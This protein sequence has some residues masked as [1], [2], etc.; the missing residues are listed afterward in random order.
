MAF[1]GELQSQFSAAQVSG[2]LGS[3]NATV[4]AAGTTQATG[5]AIAAANN[6]ITTATLNQGV[7]LPAGRAVFDQCNIANLTST[8]VCVYP[9]VGGKLNGETTNAPLIMAAFTVVTFFSIDGTSWLA[10][11]I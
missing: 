9:P 5:T 1:A 6:I 4:T 11:S 8:N 2:I 3:T 10:D 7:T